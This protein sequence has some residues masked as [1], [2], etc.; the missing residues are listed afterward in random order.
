[1][2]RYSVLLVGGLAVTLAMAP[3]AQAPAIASKPLASFMPAGPL[4]YLEGRDFAAL[5]HDWN[6]SAE[7][8]LWLE[9]DNYQVFS[10]SRLFLRLKEAQ[11]EFAAAAGLPPNMSLVESV[12]GG[13]SA[14]A[15]YD[16]GNLE[17]LYITRM[18]S[19]RAMENAL[20]RARE[21]FEPRSAAELPYY[22]RSEPAKH[23]V[24]AFATTDDLLLL[25]TREDLLAGALTR[26]AGHSGSTLKDE[27]WLSDAVQ[28]AGAMGDLRLALNMQAMVRSP[29]FRSYW[30]E[31]NVSD[32]RQYAAEIA[33][34]HRSSSEIR[35]ERVLL[36]LKPGE[37]P[38]GVAAG[39]ASPEEASLAAALRFVPD[40]AGLYRAWANPTTTNALDLLEHK[41]F[42][43]RLGPG[44][45]SKY[46]P[47]VALSEGQVGSESDLETRIDIPTL[48]NVGGTFGAEA[49]RKLLETKKL[50]AALQVQSTRALAGDVFVGTQTAVV[51]TATT[52]WEGDA[53]RAA[54]LTAIESLWTVS[55]LGAKWVERRR[56]AT[57]YYELDGLAGHAM[58]HQGRTLVVANS[59][60][61]LQKILSRTSAPPVNAGGV[62]AAGFRHA[63]ERGAMAKMMALVEK[64]LTERMP[65]RVPG[66]HEPLFFSENLASLSRALARVE[67]ESIV[68]HD[69]GP[70]VSQTVTYRLSR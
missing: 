23:R 42:A 61:F 52:D 9:S 63:R 39:T 36:R 26:I 21:K 40:D 53:T 13:E 56:G 44:V 41:V 8:K 58:A 62:Y 1:M 5:V 4:L 35:E 6:T 64:P 60:E 3:P 57:T 24:V 33:D 47:T 7:K 49:L 2:K 48:E 59:G 12:A 32:L 31:R 70:V 17:F 14:L 29:H 15:L 38:G 27:K 25:A 67:S 45:A 28:A 11:N 66:G 19:A 30:I 65:A 68:V 18:P 22:L 54:I 50:D 51:L 55:H 34:V 16:I 10:R 43:P 37:A 46:A 69:R 20:W